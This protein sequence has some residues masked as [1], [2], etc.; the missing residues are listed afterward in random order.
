MITFPHAKI[1]IGLQVTERRPDGYHN[2][3]TVF[4]PIPLHDA[5]EVIEAKDAEYDCKLH[6]SGVDI[7]GDPDSNLVVRAYRLLASDYPLPPVDIHLHKHIPTGAGL[8]GGS[9][10][11]S[12]MLRLLNEMFALNISTEKLEAYAAQLGADCPFFITAT[13]VYAT[14]IGNEFHPISLDLNDLYLVVV[15]PDVFVSTKEAYSMVHPK[16]PEVTLDKKIIAPISEWRNTISNDFEK[17]IFALHPELQEIKNKL[18]QLGAKYAAM[19][20]S[21]SALFGLFS[22]P[23]ENIEEHFVDCFCEQ[24]KLPDS[25]RGVPK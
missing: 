1:N 23:I 22:T 11:A 2:L 18:Y 24:Q 13:P 8:G 3:D 25:H 16:K 10:D 7:A 17:G 14:G 20:G 9:A 15:K 4:Y 6:L 5:L 12:F 21:G 19:S